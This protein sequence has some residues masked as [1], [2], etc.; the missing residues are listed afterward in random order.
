MCSLVF[1]FDLDVPFMVVCLAV[2]SSL[3]FD[4]HPSYTDEKFRGFNATYT[5]ESRCFN[6][7]N[8]RHLYMPICVIS[9]IT[10]FYPHGGQ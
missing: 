4:A 2:N 6:I 5:T 8:G 3:V 7:H 1:S 10:N 9:K